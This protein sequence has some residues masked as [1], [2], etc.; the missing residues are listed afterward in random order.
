[1]SKLQPLPRKRLNR[2]W[3]LEIGDVGTRWALG[4]VGGRQSPGTAMGGTTAPKRLAT[5][6]LTIINSGGTNL[7]DKCL[8]FVQDTAEAG[9]C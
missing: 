7:A 6:H 3:R 9:Q 8:L 4:R 2:S 5:A 1:M